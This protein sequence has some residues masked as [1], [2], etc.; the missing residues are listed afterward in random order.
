MGTV[1]IDD[2]FAIVHKEK[3]EDLMSPLNAQ[4]PSIKFT[5][6]IKKEGVLPFLDVEVRCTE[7]NQLQFKVFRKP[8]NTHRFIVNESHHSRQHQMAAFTSMMHRAVNIPMNDEDQLAEFA[9]IYEAAKINGYD[10][11]QIQ[12]LQTR[13]QNKKLMKQH[14]TLS[15]IGKEIPKFASIPFFPSNT[16]K[17]IRLFSKYNIQMVHTN[18]QK[19]K[20]RLGS[21][22]DK[23][24]TLQKSGTDVTQCMWV[25]PKET[26]SSVLKNTCTT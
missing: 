7:D 26:Y 14:I 5:C 23:T 20:N 4:C 16:H 10:D 12:K 21:P 11:S 18:N 9:Y 17:L 15:A 13:H 24:P 6:E 19:L 1:G 22:K 8:T 25:K 3:I 2:V